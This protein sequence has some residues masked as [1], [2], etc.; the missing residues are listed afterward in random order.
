METGENDGNSDDEAMGAQAAQ[1]EI[2]PDQAHDAAG[3]LQA[4]VSRFA[5]ED[6]G[7]LQ[8]FV[9]VIKQ[10]GAQLRATDAKVRQNRAAIDKLASQ[11][12]NYRS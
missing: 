2:V 12:R 6:E 11:I 1:A 3:Q 8:S 7:N 4:S 5:Q 10:V 9:T